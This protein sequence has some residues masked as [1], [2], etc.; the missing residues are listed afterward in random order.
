MPSHL[1][2]SLPTSLPICLPSA[3][4]ARLKTPPNTP[5]TAPNPSALFVASQSQSPRLPCFIWISWTATSIAA[6]I[7]TLMAVWIRMLSISALM[8]DWAT[9]LS[10]TSAAAAE[11]SAA[12]LTPGI[13]HTAARN[14][15]SAIS[16]MTWPRIIHFAYSAWVAVSRAILARF[17]A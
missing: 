2:A 8:T 3:P 11:A 14:A 13:H 6:P 1:A 12:A 17:S 10:A 9:T 15:S 4:P 7:V 16:W 5:C